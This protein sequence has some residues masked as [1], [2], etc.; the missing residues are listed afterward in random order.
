MAKYGDLGFHDPIKPKGKEP[1]NQPVEGKDTPWTF[2]HPKY[3]ER[4]SCFIP[5]GTH[6]G[7]GHNQPVGHEGESKQ[8][9]EC[10]PQENRT[11]SLSENE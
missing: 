9:V 6:Y 10:F 7:I 2:K 4:S 8:H 3:D 11:S 1:K 5:G